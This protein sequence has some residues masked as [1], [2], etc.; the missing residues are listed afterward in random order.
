M[1]QQARIVHPLIHA[2]QFG[3]TFTFRRQNS[4]AFYERVADPHGHSERRRE[5][6][7]RKNLAFPKGSNCL[8]AVRVA[9]V[10]LRAHLWVLLYHRF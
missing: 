4:S 7:M 10:W 1:L 2:S 3:S 8:V 6:P 9:V 5:A